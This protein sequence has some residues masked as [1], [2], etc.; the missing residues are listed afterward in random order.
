MAPEPEVWSESIK[1]HQRDE[2]LKTGKR[3]YT[4]LLQ[5]GMKLSLAANLVL[6]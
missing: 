3:K 2:I 6:T 1:S 4:R 5:R